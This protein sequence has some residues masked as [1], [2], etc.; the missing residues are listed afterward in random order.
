MNLY[1]HPGMSQ[2]DLAEASGRSIEHYDALPQMEKRGLL[3]R[4]NGPGQARDA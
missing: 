3:T 1:R 4:E 2:H